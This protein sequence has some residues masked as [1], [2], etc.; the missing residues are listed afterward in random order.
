MDSHKNETT[1]V[2]SLK[3]NMH[4]LSNKV[5]S[6]RKVSATENI[7]IGLETW[8]MDFSFPYLKNVD[9]LVISSLVTND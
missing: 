6:I 7:I 5:L 9:M 4:H 3:N 8:V 2:S 1:R